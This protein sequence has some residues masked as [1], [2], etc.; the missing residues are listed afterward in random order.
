MGR[1]LT[2][3]EASKKAVNRVFN[4]VLDLELL[5]V[6][7]IG[8][9]PSHLLRLFFYTL[10][11][12]KIGRGSRIHIGARFFY[13][14]NIKIGEGTIIGDNIFLDG[15]EKL[16]IG[17]HVDI[18]SGVMIYNSE[19]DIN[20]EDFHAIS[21]PVE[22]GDFVF[23]GPRAIILPGVKIGRG[24]VVAAGAVVTKDVTEDAIV[25]GVPAE[26]I[27]ERKVKNLHY[28]LGRARLFQ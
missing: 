3:T 24:A 22:I 28:R 12:V 13:P 14:A 16:I 8:L 23:I 18:A 10:A 6:T 26:V 15:R 19:H 2:T 1:P 9:V 20:S 4:W 21:A 25:G 11:G 27:G 17:N 5:L 7:W